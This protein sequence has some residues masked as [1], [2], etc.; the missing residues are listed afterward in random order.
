MRKV[1]RYENGRPVWS[2]NDPGGRAAVPGFGGTL[3]TGLPT[4][5][6]KAKLDRKAPKR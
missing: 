3:V 2:E 5:E 6:D 4:G 1:L